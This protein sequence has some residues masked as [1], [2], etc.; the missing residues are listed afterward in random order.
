MNAIAIIPGRPGTAGLINLPEP[1]KS[2]GSVL[3]RTRSIGLCGT[4]LEIAL[5]GYGVPP[6]GQERLRNLLII[7]SRGEFNYDYYYHFIELKTIDFNPLKKIF[8][9]YYVGAL[10]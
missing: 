3:V 1:P 2:D 4:D 6:P 7:K 9:D 5:N 8:L 10:L